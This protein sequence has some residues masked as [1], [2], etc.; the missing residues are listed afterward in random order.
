MSYTFD[1]DHMFQ[2]LNALARGA[3]RFFAAL[4]AA[5]LE[6]LASDLRN[7]VA[8]AKAGGSANF[9][10]GTR[11]DL[12]IEIA[13]SSCWKGGTGAFARM[14]AA[15]RLDYTCTYK[16]VDARVQIK[17]VG[18]LTIH[19]ASGA[20]QKV[21]HFD[22]EEGGWTELKNGVLVD[23]A[24]HPPFHS[25]FYGFVNDIPRMASLIVHPVDVINFAIL[26]LHQKRWRDHVA[27][28][29]AKSQLRYFPPRQRV[30]L[31]TILESWG[32]QIRN[33][34]YQA[35]VSMQRPFGAPLAL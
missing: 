22:V 3:S 4:S 8:S 23:R 9:G 29:D 30:R 5:R 15:I 25:Q 27:T 31:A 6:R 14:A 1:P 17:G 10:W 32:R 21:V 34:D 7:A 20:G 18:V 19:H 2:D 28:F 24:G 11:P 13:T 12:P 35:L 26:E 33:S 16:P